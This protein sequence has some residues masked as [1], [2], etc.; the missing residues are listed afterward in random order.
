[1]QL[2]YPDKTQIEIMQALSR[3]AWNRILERAQDLHLRRKLATSLNFNGPHPANPYHRT[4][5]S[6]DLEAVADLVETEEEKNPYPT[7]RQ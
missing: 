4:M 7:D 1:M 5:R 3:R 2:L 6:S